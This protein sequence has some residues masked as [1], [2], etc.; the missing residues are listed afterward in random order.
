MNETKPGQNSPQ[1]A[2]IRFIGFA[3]EKI[4]FEWFFSLTLALHLGLGAFPELRNGDVTSLKGVEI[5]E[6]R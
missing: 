1:Y 2:S 4:T 6:V 5:D 3:C